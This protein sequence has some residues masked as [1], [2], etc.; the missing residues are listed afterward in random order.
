MFLPR[1]FLRRIIMSNSLG[2]YIHIPFCRS[3]CPYCDFFS[4]RGTYSDYKEY[5][6]VLEDRI[7]A[8]GCAYKR[9]VN[10]VYFGG[11]TPS[12]IGEKLLC[13]LIDE[14]KNSFNVYDNA[15]ITLEVNPDSGKKLDFF[16]LRSSGF[17]RI[18]IGMQSAVPDELKILGRLHSA[19]DVISTV[20]NVKESGIENVS[21]DLM[22]GV[23]GQTTDSLKYSIDFCTSLGVKHISS[24]ILKLEENTYYYKNSDKYT[25]PDDDLTAELY[26][27]AVDYLAKKGYKQ[28]EISNFSIPGFESRHN[29]RYWKLEDYLGIGASA[30]SLI[31]G[32]RF[33]YGRSIEDF[34][35]DRII[36]DG[37]GGTEEE[38]IMLSLRLSEGLDLDKLKIIRGGEPDPEFTNKCDKFINAGLMKLDGRRLSLTP[39]GYL[40]SNS[41]ISDLI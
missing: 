16:K 6:D 41:I 26:L 22:L 14:I 36:E 18:S 1:P 17:N 8:F 30:H 19:N 29:L 13:E 12:V 27:L 34:K 7:R 15:E 40:L 28:Y 20:N 23:P 9:D 38:F 32:R 25:F 39:N 5:A 3:K 11:G 4:K 33:Y 35:C 21:L 10:T 24:Y 31:D 2:L 37:E